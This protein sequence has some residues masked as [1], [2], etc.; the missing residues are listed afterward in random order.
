MTTT[1]F[2]SFS[3]WDQ[4]WKDILADSV[5]S[6]VAL[7]L[8]HINV[9]SLHKHWNQLLVHLA[10][11]LDGLDVLILTETNTDIAAC[12]SFS[13]DGFHTFSLCGENQR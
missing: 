3:E 6:K 5:E 2:E 12:D 4:N 13:L 11:R 7:N 10:D 8:V 1:A 9:R